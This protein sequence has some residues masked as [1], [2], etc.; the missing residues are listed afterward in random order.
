MRF[1]RG[2]HRHGMRHCRRTGACGLKDK[3]IVLVGNPNVGKSVIFGYLTGVYAE[4]SNY[5][6]TTIEISQGRS[7]W[8]TVQDTP[9]I[10]GV[11]SFNDEERVARDIILG[12]DVIVNVVSAVHLERDLFLTLQLADMGIPMLVLLNFMDEAQDEGLEIDAGLLSDILGVPVVPASAVNRTGLDNIAAAIKDA[13][14]GHAQPEV[15]ALTTEALYKA[16]SRAEAVLVLEGDQVVAKRHG[17]HPGG[18]REKIYVLRR[19]RVNDIVG[20]VV[21]ETGAARRFAARL[22]QLTMNPWTGIPIFLAAL[23][24]IYLVIGV[25]VAQ[26]V[27]GFTEGS[28]MQ[29]HWEPLVRSA[30]F[31]WLPPNS[32]PGMLLAGEYGMFTMAV[33]YL[34]GLLLPLV[35]GFYFSLAFLEDSGYLPRLATLADRVLGGIGLNG[36][37]VIPIILGF[38]C[39]TMGTITTRLLGTER[40]K[41]I[42]ASILNFTIPCSA[43][44]GVIALLLGRIGFAYSLTYVLVIG[45]CLVLVGTVLNR[46]LPGESS[47]LL[48]DLPPMRMPRMGNVIR[49]TSLRT[50]L[51]MKEAFPWFLAGSLLIAVMQVTGLLDAWHRLLS[52]LVVGWLQLP[53]QAADAFVVGMIRRDFGAAEIAGMVLTAPQT[54][55]ALIAMTLYVPCTASVAILFKERGWREALTIWAATWISSFAVGGAVSQLVIR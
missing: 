28:I 55:V 3:K 10:Y 15:A 16:G 11:A 38:G 23:Y 25:F 46:S 29:G 42:A 26:H 39:I 6:G 30:V 18:M 34:F 45:G 21:R 4:V 40:E 13:R 5:P 12:A 33:T 27:V 1:T 41:T 31:K 19:E 49:K 20:H 43:Q 53:I 7:D 50:M 2:L 9:G 37:A 22:A 52:P 54:L 8:G 32:V 35:V 36:R 17:V 47:S 14:P 24:M 44:L 48:I 51:F